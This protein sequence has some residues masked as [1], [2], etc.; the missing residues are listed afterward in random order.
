MVKLEEDDRGVLDEAID[1]FKGGLTFQFGYELT[2]DEVVEAT[3]GLK[4]EEDLINVV[5]E[6]DLNVS[7]VSVKEIVNSF[8]LRWKFVLKLFVFLGLSIDASNKE[9]YVEGL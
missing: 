5:F 9:H 1:L 6:D 2:L 7:R 4:S 8:F 3:S